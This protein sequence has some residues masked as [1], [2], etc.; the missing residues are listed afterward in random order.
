M[1]LLGNVI[2]IQ[3]IFAFFLVLFCFSLAASVRYFTIPC[4]TF[5]YCVCVT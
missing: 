3:D 2:T 1:M 5:G 4:S